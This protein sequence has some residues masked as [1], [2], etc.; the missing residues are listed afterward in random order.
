MLF[1]NKGFFFFPVSITFQLN[2]TRQ[3]S[4]RIMEVVQPP[5]DIVGLS[6]QIY[7]ICSV[8]SKIE[9]LISFYLLVEYSVEHTYL[10]S[11]KYLR[12]N[13]PK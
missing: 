5:A 11:S 12:K 6:K 10:H 4:E 2:S 7:I 13:S 9:Y 8:S 3:K 1:T